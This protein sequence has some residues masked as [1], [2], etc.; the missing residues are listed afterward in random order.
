M[1]PFLTSWKSIAGAYKDAIFSAGDTRHF[2]RELEKMGVIQKKFESFFE[3]Y[4]TQYKEEL[5]GSPENWRRKFADFA[6]NATDF[7]ANLSLARAVGLDLERTG[8]LRWYDG[9]MIATYAMEAAMNG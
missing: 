3:Q 5:L 7:S 1:G 9:D 8:I 4:R 2:T 6:D